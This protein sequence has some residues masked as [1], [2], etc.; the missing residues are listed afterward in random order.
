MMKQQTYELIHE[1]ALIECDVIQ[2]ED[3]PIFHNIP[4]TLKMEASCALVP[5]VTSELQSVTL[6]SHNH[7][8]L[9]PGSFFRQFTLQIGHYLAYCT[10]SRW[11]L[12]T[13]HLLEGKLATGTSPNATLFTT[14]QTRTDLGSNPC[15]CDAKL[16]L[17][18]WAMERPT[19]AVTSNIQSSVNQ[20]WGPNWTTLSLGII[21]TGTWALGDSQDWDSQIWS[22]VPRVSHPRKTML[23]RT[24]NNWKLQ[25]RP[26]V[27]EGAHIK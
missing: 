4:L 26:L 5:L 12:S 21:S 11:E 23:A 8:N 18:A 6:H 20:A 19:L 17:T 3:S 2:S 27:R 16:G 9:K 13:N 14:N 22:Y 10:S 7:D 15:H 24:G 1:Y 25:I